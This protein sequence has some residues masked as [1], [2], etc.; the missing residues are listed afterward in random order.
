MPDKQKDFYEDN[1]QYYERNA[2][3]YEAASWYYF[4]A[5]KERSVIGELRRCLE[6]AK[7][8]GEA[9]SVL[10]I[11]PGTGYLLDKLLA[12]TGQKV[13]Y[14]AIEH[15]EAMAVILRRR[16]EH[17]CGS[18]KVISEH[19]S[20]PLIK[21]L[22]LDRGFDIVM[23]SSILHHLP[24]YEDT[25]RELAAHVKPGGVMYFV[26]EPLHREEVARSGEL[27]DMIERVYAAM[28]GILMKP[29]LRT[30]LWPNKVKA[31][32]ASG[33]AIHMFKD[34][35]SSMVFKE[36]EARGFQRVLM[37]KYNRRLSA[38]LSYME[39]KWLASLRK[40]IHGNTLYS[41]CLRKHP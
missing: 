3:R 13:D 32:D 27:A 28:N 34:G 5:Y 35:V 23:G 24:D 10:E 33:I 40:D 7:G 21:S 17:R 16:F 8:Q 19:V 4:N 1:K 11:G 2:A 18:F 22:A 14:V 15:S 41:I 30:R 29:W 9:V 38:L 36:L 12:L 25:V 37:R 39:N 31:E 6:L 26:R 20:A